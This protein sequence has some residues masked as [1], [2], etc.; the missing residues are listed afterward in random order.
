MPRRFGYGLAMRNFAVREGDGVQ[1]RRSTQLAAGG[2]TSPNARVVARVGRRAL[3]LQRRR[4]LVF[5]DVED[6][7]LI[8]VD[9]VVGHL[10]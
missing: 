3:A 5:E 9:A 6:V 4:L 2:E 8:D 1:A 7:H 10:F